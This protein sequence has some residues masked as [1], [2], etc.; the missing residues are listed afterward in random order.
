M[1]KTMYIM[2]LTMMAAMVAAC[3]SKQQSAES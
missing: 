2:A 3:G 1:K